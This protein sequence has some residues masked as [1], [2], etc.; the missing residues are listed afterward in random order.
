MFA[1]THTSIHTHQFVCH[2]EQDVHGD[3]A[4]GAVLPLAVHHDGWLLLKP[5]QIVIVLAIVEWVAGGRGRRLGRSVGVKLVAIVTDADLKLNRCVDGVDHGGREEGTI[6]L[7][8]ATPEE[9]LGG[10]TQRS[11]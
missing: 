7:V 4:V 11:R 9:G 10:E 1:C 2:I 3:E 5:R 8:P 6:Q